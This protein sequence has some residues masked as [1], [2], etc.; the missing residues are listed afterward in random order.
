MPNTPKTRDEQMLAG[1]KFSD[2]SRCRSCGASVEWWI[3]PKGNKMP[4][5]PMLTGNDPWV[6]HFATCPNADNHR[7]AR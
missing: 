4:V 5:D 1:Y 6:S 3:T 7:R 2:H